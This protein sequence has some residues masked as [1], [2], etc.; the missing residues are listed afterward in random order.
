MIKRAMIAGLNSTGVD[1]ADLRV[2]PAAVSRHL[3]KT[4]GY[5]AGSTSASARAT[6]RSIEIQFFEQPGIQMTSALEKEVEKHFNRRELR[7]VPFG[8]IGQVT[9]PARVRESYAQDLLSELDADAIRARGFRIVV[10][11]GYSAASFVLPLLLGPL[12]RRSGDRARV[13]DRPGRHRGVAARVDRPCEAARLGDRRRT[14]GW[15]ST[16]RASACSSSTSRATSCPVEKTLLLF[17]RLLGADG[18]AGKV[19]VPVTVTSRVE[20]L[21]GEAGLEVRADARAPRPS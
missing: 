12:G 20:E 2:L 3:M 6:P 13:H 10:D 11:Y 18:E 14:S 7:R 17:L 8:D 9:Y 4:Q 5:D 15:S 1:V 19:A 21:A 16:G